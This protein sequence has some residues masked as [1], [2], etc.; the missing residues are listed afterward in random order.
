MSGTERFD[1]PVG[2]IDDM[3]DRTQASLHDA[4]GRAVAPA[5]MSGG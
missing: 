1:A 5:R 2:W 4:R 3:L